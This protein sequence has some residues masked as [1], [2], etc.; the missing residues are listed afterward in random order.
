[1]SIYL[2]FSFASHP[3]VTSLLFLHCHASTLFLKSILRFLEG[4]S[5]SLKQITRTAGCLGIRT[6]ITIELKISGDFYFLVIRRWGLCL[7]RL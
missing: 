3:F 1:M 6:G 2:F 5:Q 7:L 4:I